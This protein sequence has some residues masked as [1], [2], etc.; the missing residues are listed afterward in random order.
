MD[1][2]I[3]FL[4]KPL[5][6]QYIT[7]D[8]KVGNEEVP[9]TPDLVFI[10]THTMK[11]HTLEESAPKNYN[12]RVYE[13]RCGCL[14]LAKILLNENE[15][16]I[17]LKNEKKQKIHLLFLKE[18]FNLSFDD[19]ENLLKKNIKKEIYSVSEVS[20]IIGL[21]EKNLKETFFFDINKIDNEN[22]LKIFNRILHVIRE[23]ERVLIF[24]EKSKKF[25]EI[26]NPNEEDKKKIFKE[27]GDLLNGSHVSCRDLYECSCDELEQLRNIALTSN[28][29]IGARLTG[30]GWG[31]AL[32]SC[33]KKDIIDDFM[34]L[35]WD[36]YYIKLK[37]YKGKQGNVLFSSI[38]SRGAVILI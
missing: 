33:I 5:I 32:I 28:G 12:K 11:E 15:F 17:Y 19:L 9:I 10:V 38:P 37:K 4:G 31:G 13:C 30:A 29:C 26:K 20:K 25:M 34:K 27:L 22:N 2:A 36:E 35:M 23:S 21:E 1:Q 24:K 7:F 3:S 16:K 18:K 8:P 6:S 14:L